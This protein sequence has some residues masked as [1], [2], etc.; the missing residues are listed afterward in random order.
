[1]RVEDKDK[2]RAYKGR[3]SSLQD[4]TMSRTVK[5]TSKRVLSLSRRDYWYRM[6][7]MGLL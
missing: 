5:R 6:S 7:R 2:Q 4:V 1:M 3:R